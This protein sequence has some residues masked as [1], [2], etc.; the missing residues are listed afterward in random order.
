MSVTISYQ[1]GRCR[2][3]ST[4]SSSAAP[5][6]EAR[7]ASSEGTT[8]TCTPSAP[9]AKSIPSTASP[10]A[11]R[12]FMNASVALSSSNSSSLRRSKGSVSAP[13][14][15]RASANSLHT[16]LSLCTFPASFT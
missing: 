4:T 13:R 9:Y 1:G 15:V 16:P 12:S 2:N 5:S 3:G 11:S 14:S 10:S 8:V 6:G 7:S